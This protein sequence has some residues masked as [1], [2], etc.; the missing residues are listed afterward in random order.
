VPAALRERERAGELSLNRPTSAGRSSPGDVAIL[1]HG[2][3]LK[4]FFANALLS[5]T[6]R[7]VARLTRSTPTM[8]DVAV[9]LQRH[10]ISHG[11]PGSTP[12][13]AEPLTSPDSIDPR[14]VR[15]APIA[16]TGRPSNYT[17]RSS[18]GDTSR[19]SS[20]GDDGTLNVL[21]AHDT[22]G[23]APGPA[24]SLRSSTRSVSARATTAA[25]RRS[26]SWTESGIT[27]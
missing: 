2:R 18:E 24:T 23:G 12:D 16:P 25:R 14:R 27:E 7:P 19:W 3:S 22:Q 21:P 17:R 9:D 6:E 15:T 13:A 5:V 11:N 1:S 8:A 26:R 20:G 10:A 4:D